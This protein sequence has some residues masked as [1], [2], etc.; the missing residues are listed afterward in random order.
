[1]RERSCQPV[2]VGETE[3]SWRMWG[4]GGETGSELCLL[5]CLLASSL[6]VRSPPPPPQPSVQTE[7]LATTSQYNCAKAPLPVLSCH[8]DS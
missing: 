3:R 2:T 6:L 4:G 5:A 1:M 8:V 7:G